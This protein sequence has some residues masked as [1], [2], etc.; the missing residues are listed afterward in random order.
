MKLRN[1]YAITQP[2]IRQGFFFV[3]FASVDQRIKKNLL[4][5]MKLRNLH[6][7]T[8]PDVRHGKSVTTYCVLS[9][10]A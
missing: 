1:L 3:A 6:V 7:I 10:L 8:Q 9:T 5:N 4:P 2:S